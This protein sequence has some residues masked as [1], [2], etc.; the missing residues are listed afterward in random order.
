[1]AAIV[2]AGVALGVLSSTLGGDYIPRPGIDAGGLAAWGNLRGAAMLGALV[3]GGL[4][5]MALMA[6]L[7]VVTGSTALGIALPVAA[8]GMAVW[9]LPTPIEQA[10]LITSDWSLPGG[11]LAFWTLTV[12][13]PTL[14]A[15]ALAGRARPGPLRP[16]T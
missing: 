11:L 9:F 15:L 10:F 5:V 12:S 7:H 3:A 4:A 2:P 13:G 16:A 8:Y 14:C 1:V 6:L